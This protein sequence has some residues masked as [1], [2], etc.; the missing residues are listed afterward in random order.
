[1]AIK[2]R[3]DSLGHSL[4]MNGYELRYSI[5]LRKNRNAWAEIIE[6][7]AQSTVSKEALM[8]WYE[9]HKIGKNCVI[10]LEFLLLFFRRKT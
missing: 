4:D 5:D 3:R 7:V 2:E 8:R 9:R 10:G 6:K 1:M